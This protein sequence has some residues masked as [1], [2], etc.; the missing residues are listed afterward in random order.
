VTGLTGTE[1]LA[2]VVVTIVCIALVAVMLSVLQRL[3]RRR[4]QLRGELSRRPEALS[5]RAFN[6]IAMARREADVLNR[7]GTDTNRPRELIGEAQAAFDRRDFDR[8]YTLAQSAHET[9]VAARQRPPSAAPATPPPARDGPASPPAEAAAPPPASRLPAHRA[10]SQFQ[11][12]LLEDEVARARTSRPKDG[13]TLEAG[14]LLEQAQQAFGRADYAEAFRLALRGR[15]EAG[16]SV[17]ALPAA[18]SARSTGGTAAGRPDPATVADA[19][20]SANRCPSCGHPMSANDAFCRGCG[21]PRATATCPKCGTERLP[22]DTFCGR[23]G[24]SFA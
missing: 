14:A 11:I 24:A 17:E 6:R 9:L 23:C 3:R 19:L 8:A 10:E 1:I 12:R 22:S 21:T 7:Q 20:A 2:V 13:R 18:P 16:G 4:D 15:R 5:D